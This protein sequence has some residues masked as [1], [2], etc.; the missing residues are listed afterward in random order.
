MAAGNAFLAM[1]GPIGWGIAGATLLTSILLFA[2]KKHDIKGERQKELTAVKENTE[3]V[4]E[5]SVEVESLAKKTEELRLRLGEL[6]SQ[7]IRLFGSDFSVLSVDDQDRLAA[8]VN[9]TLALSRL[10][11]E[12]LTQDGPSEEQVIE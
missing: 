8:M 9:D 4:A 2:K 12:R 6:Y 7:C 11:S 5:M 3:R 1:A 10:L